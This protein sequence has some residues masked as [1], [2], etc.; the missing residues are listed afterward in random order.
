MCRYL[1]R[2]FFSLNQSS[3]NILSPPPQYW[4]PPGRDSVTYG[5]QQLFITTLHTWWHHVLPPTNNMKTFF[6]ILS[7]HTMEGKI[8]KHCTCW[9]HCHYLQNCLEWYASAVVTAQC[10]C[11]GRWWRWRQ[12]GTNLFLW[13]PDK[14]LHGVDKLQNRY[15]IGISQGLIRVPVPVTQR[16]H[17]NNRAKDFAENQLSLYCPSDLIASASLHCS[18]LDTVS[19]ECNTWTPPTN[20]NEAVIYNKEERRN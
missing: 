10:Q 9:L 11:S 15:L 8:L 16:T 4:H 2:N 5:G 7:L 13:T 12:Q 1:A 17:S 6:D 3:I 19:V 20:N 18:I 14:C